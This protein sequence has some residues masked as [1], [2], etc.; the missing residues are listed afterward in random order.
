MR[1][2]NGGQMW[3]TANQLPTFNSAGRDL[4][5]FGIF[6][7]SIYHKVQLEKKKWPSAVMV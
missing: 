2:P 6:V 4:K 7:T 5:K 1:V 3:D